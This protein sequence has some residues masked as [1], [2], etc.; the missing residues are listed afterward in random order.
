MKI[1]SYCR[2]GSNAWILKCDKMLCSVNKVGNLFA[3][4]SD[5]PPVRK[6]WKFYSKQKMSESKSMSRLGSDFSWDSKWIIPV[7]SSIQICFRFLSLL[8]R[9]CI[10][11]EGCSRSHV[12]SFCANFLW[13]PI[14]VTTASKISWFDA[15]CLSIEP[16]AFIKSDWNGFGWLRSAS[17]CGKYALT[18]KINFTHK[19]SQQGKF[20]LSEP[21]K[22]GYFSVLTDD[23]RKEVFSHLDNAGFAASI[24]V[25]MHVL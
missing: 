1:T 14:L 10:T 11:C 24:Q 19:F 16:F 23:L 12:F 15:F 2:R 6:W 4:P 20:F 17:S 13:W 25:R 7:D 3:S 5:L 22:E 8:F 21:E 9:Y 18:N